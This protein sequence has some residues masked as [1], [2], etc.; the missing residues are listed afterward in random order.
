MKLLIDVIGWSGSVMVITAYGLNSYQ[1]IKSDSLLFLF[2][3][4]IGG[5]FLIIYSV[6]YTAYANTFINVVWVI[7]AIP[8][9]IKLIGNQPDHGNR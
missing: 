4:L 8:A 6:Y 9:L 1:K 2:L 5:I 3:N 7:I